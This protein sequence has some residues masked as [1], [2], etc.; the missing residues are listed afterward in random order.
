MLNIRALYYPY[1]TMA[2]RHRWWSVA[3]AC[4][5]CLIGWSAVMLIPNKYE[6]SARLYVDADAVL[7]PLLK[8]IA[9]ESAPGSQIDLLHRTLLSRPNIEALIARTNLKSRGTSPA[10]LESLSQRLAAEVKVVTPTKNLFSVTYSD[11]S[12]TQAYE[13]VNTLLTIF[14]ESRTAATRNDLDTAR[15]FLA[16]QIAIYEETLRK[17]EARKTEFQNRYGDLLPDPTGGPSRLSNAIAQVSAAKTQLAELKV[18]ITVLQ[19]E[20]ATIP[21]AVKLVPDGTK[22]AAASAGVTASPELTRAE[23]ELTALR[24][25]YTDTHPDVVR[26]RELVGR[27]RATG[28]GAGAATTDRVVPN[29]VYERVKRDLVDTQLAVASL[30]QRLAAATVERDRLQV[31]SRDAPTVQSDFV[32]IKREYEEAYNGY[33]ELLRRREAMRLTEAADTGVDKIRAQIVDPPV[34]PL[35]PVSPKR[36]TL[37]SAVFAVACLGAI[38]L[39]LLLKQFDR[40]FHSLMELEVLDLPIA[41]GISAID[42]SRSLISQCLSVV[43]LSFMI[44]L[45]GGIYAVLLLWICEV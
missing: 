34:V 44:L 12:P 29:P 4:L 14:M 26:A 27:L 33:T 28:L 35:N 9:L 39:P 25:R 16:E 1:L 13:V 43:S 6:V 37:V 21:S 11:G 8:G 32:N 36:K 41:G 15:Q 10:A 19:R 42:G 5:V 18:K 24:L 7:T 2:W 40:S 30:E 17:A 20:L 38:G 3:V 31:M 23:L 22:S 45:L